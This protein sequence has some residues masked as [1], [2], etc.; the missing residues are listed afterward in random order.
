MCRLAANG[1]S[2]LKI[3]KWYGKILGLLQKTICPAFPSPK[4]SGLQYLNRTAQGRSVEKCTPRRF[5]QTMPY[6]QDK[7]DRLCLGCANRIPL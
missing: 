2:P 6:V 1:Y 7:L 5:S 4:N 3:S